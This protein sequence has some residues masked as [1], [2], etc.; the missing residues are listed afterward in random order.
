MRPLAH[1]PTGAA[2]AAGNAIL[3]GLSPSERRLLEPLD[4]LRLPARYVLFEAGDALKQLYFPAS[5]VVSFVQADQRG[6]MAE[7]AHVGAEGMTGVTALL[8]AERARHRAVMQVGGA[9]YRV[10]LST[11]RRAFEE[12]RTFRLLA[13]GFAEAM[14]RQLSQNVICKLGHSVEQQ[15]CQRLLLYADRLAGAALEMT[16]EQLAET[17]GARRQGITETARRL[18]A[19]QVIAYSRGRI[20]V[21]DRAALERFACECYR[22]VRGV[23]PPATPA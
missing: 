13:L 2:V 14:M 18:Q 3:A 23:A 12:N 15:L 11:A 22:V 5:G 19:L 7:I 20:S 8:G 17:L 10:P 6:L 9:V 21:L 1:A 16:H 4:Y